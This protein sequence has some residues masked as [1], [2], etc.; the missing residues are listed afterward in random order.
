MM[1][2]RPR[3]S[4]VLRPSRAL[5]LVCL[6]LGLLIA[7][8]VRA[9]PHIWVDSYFDVIFTGDK[10]SAVRVY[11]TYDPVFSSVLLD[12]F[13]EDRDEAFNAAESDRLREQLLL[14]LDE[15]NFY[16]W[17]RA[18]GQVLTIRDLEDV[19]FGVEA[20]AVTVA[21]TVPLPGGVDPLTQD[22]KVGLYD[23]T[24]YVDLV[25]DVVDPV[26]FRGP[27]PEACGFRVGE[28]RANPLYF[29]TFFPTV[30]FIDCR[31]KS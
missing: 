19:S 29:G 12:E 25:L 4:A 31:A 3:S 20:A 15:F 26:R 11:W 24:Y 8:P 18:D 6:W 13:D 16:T 9:H 2:W 23:E 30:T 1:R 7:S 22:L 27:V 14:P 17:I 21:F 28:D 10:V 5:G